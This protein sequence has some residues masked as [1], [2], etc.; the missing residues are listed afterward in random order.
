MKPH[1]LCLCALLV[2]GHAAQLDH[3]KVGADMAAAA[4]AFLKSLSPAQTDQ[5]CFAFDSDERE[6]WHFIPKDRLGLPLK[7]LDDKQLV[8][9]RGLL[10]SAMSEKGLLKVDTIILLEAYLA[11]LENN[12]IRRDAKK[13]HTSI[14]GVP[15]VGGTWGW[16]FEGHHLSLNFTLHESGEIAVTPSFFAANRAH[17]NEGPMAGTRPLGAEEDLARALATALNATGKAAVYSDRAPN[18]ILTAAD[19]K[20]TQLLPVGA[21]ASDFT[22]SQR[23]GLVKLIVEYAE[24]FRPEL[25]RNQL[26]KIMADFTNLHFGWAGGLEPGQ[27][28]YYRIQGEN[29][30]IEVS[31][32]QNE[33]NHIHVVW[34]DRA[35]DFGRDVL[36]AHHHEHKH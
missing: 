36:G 30:L 1:L 34:R 25:A 29:F 18:D 14:F 31:N 17:V 32:V 28:Y 2:S 33:A 16:R 22:E 26:D 13:Y 15:K 27:G 21:K 24:R 11:E 4:N 10:E 12:P 5:A 9:Q 23:E 19:R 35:G 8:L 6:N 3:A 20:L 7:D